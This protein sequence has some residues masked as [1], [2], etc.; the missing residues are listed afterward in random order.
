MK[1]SSVLAYFLS[2]FF[3]VLSPLRAE[4]VLPH[5]F[6]DHMVMQR[7]AEIRVWGWADPGE[8]ISVSLGTSTGQAT[9]DADGRWRVTLPAMRAGGPFALTV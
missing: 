9:T 2:F 7:E 5:L 8:I 3:F 6:S 4:P 1:N